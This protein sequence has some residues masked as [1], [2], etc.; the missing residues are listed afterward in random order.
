MLAQQAQI[1][2]HDAAPPRTSELITKKVRWRMR[3]FLLAS[4]DI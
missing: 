2:A 4:V 1:L 3:P